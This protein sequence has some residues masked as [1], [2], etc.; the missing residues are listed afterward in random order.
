MLAFSCSAAGGRGAPSMP[1]GARCSAATARVPDSGLGIGVVGLFA[2]RQV[3]VAI[4]HEPDVLGDVGGVVADALEV[5]CH[6][7]QVGAAGDGAR[8]FHHV[9]QEFAEQA[10][11]FGV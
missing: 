6:E 4:G 7:Q 3:V 1:Q 10:R 11:V 9:G 2:R 8:V 5:L